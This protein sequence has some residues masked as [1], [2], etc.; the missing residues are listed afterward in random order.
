MEL[1]VYNLSFL[2][3]VLEYRRLRNCGRAQWLVLLEI[4][5]TRGNPGLTVPVVPGTRAWMLQRP[6]IE[7]NKQQT[8]KRQKSMKWF[9]MVFCYT[10]RPEYSYNSHQRVFIQQLVGVDTKTQSQTLGGGRGILYRGGRKDCRSLRGSRTPQEHAQQNQLPRTHIASQKLSRQ[11]GSLYGSDPGPLHVCDAW[12]TCSCGISSN[13]IRDC[14]WLL[15]LFWGP[16]PSTGLSHPAL[17]WGC[18]PGLIVTFYAV[19]G[20]PVLFLRE[21]GKVGLGVKGVGGISWKE[22]SVGKLQWTCS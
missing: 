17:M 13:G 19:F 1:S 4:P 14:F 16:F 2:Q 5:A 15:C 9:L 22:G 21:T 3:D 8:N 10:H 20:R 18:V 7:P 11:S 12:V 6:R